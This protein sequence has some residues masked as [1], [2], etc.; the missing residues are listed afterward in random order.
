M[1]QTGDT[2][3]DSVW[4]FSSL[5]KSVIIQAFPS[6]KQMNKWSHQVK[7]HRWRMTGKLPVIEYLLSPLLPSKCSG[8]RSFPKANTKVFLEEP[9]GV[10]AG[11]QP[12]R[13]ARDWLCHEVIHLYHLLSLWFLSWSSGNEAMIWTS[14]S[15]EYLSLLQSWK[16]KINYKLNTFQRE[17][18]W[19]IHTQ[20]A[21]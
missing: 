2:L 6:K 19:Y 12:G 14:L 5:Y 3:A 9:E 10:W 1:L 13:R 8:V 16:K 18:N 15:H 21:M 11:V 4:F 7:G 20:N 17:V